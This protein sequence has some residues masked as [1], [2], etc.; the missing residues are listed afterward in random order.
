MAINVKDRKIYALNN[1]RGLDKENKPL[2]VASFRATE[3]KNFVIDSKTLKTRQAVKFNSNFAP[4]ILDTGDSIVDFYKFHDI[5]IY[6]TKKHF[7]FYDTS[8]DVLNSGFVY[9][10]PFNETMTIQ[11][12]VGQTAFIKGTM[13]IINNEGKTPLF[14]E[15]KDSLFIF[16]VGFIFVFSKIE[17][18]L[19]PYY[20]FYELESKPSSSLIENLPSIHIPTLLIGE[21]SFD[22]VNLLSKKHKYKL[23]TDSIEAKNGNKV[24]K[25][26]T[27]YD[28]GKHGTFS[29]EIK[30]YKGMFDDIDLFPV[31]I[32]VLGEHVS[33]ED[34][35]A[36]QTSFGI[37]YEESEQVVTFDVNETYNS[38]IPAEYKVNASSVTTPTLIV[39]ESTGLTNKDFFGLT[40]DYLGSTMT[41]FNFLIYR[42]RNNHSSIISNFVYKFSLDVVVDAFYRDETSNSLLLNKKR[43]IT[44]NVYVQIHPYTNNT[45]ARTGETI[46]HNYRKTL[47]SE[48]WIENPPYPSDDL[49]GYVQI[50]N[51]DFEY[52]IPIGNFQSFINDLKVKAN[53]Y[54]F[55]NLSTLANGDKLYISPQVYIPE[56]V[57]HSSTK[58]MNSYTEWLKL[59]STPY[60]IASTP[61]T[62]N[63]NDFPDVSVW[64]PTETYVPIIKFN[65]TFV[66][67]SNPTHRQVIQSAIDSMNLSGG[68]QQIALRYYLEYLVEGQYVSERYAILVNV[69]VTI[70]SQTNY[71]HRYSVIMKFTLDKTVVSDDTQKFEFNTIDNIFELTVKDY[72][73]D[74]MNEPAIEVQ[75]NFEK[76]PDY[77]IISKSKFGTIF[78]SE[79][80]LFLSGHPSYPNIDRYNV[81][82]DLLGN[83]IASQSYEFTYF[84]SKNYRVVGGKG[85]INGYVVATDSQLYVT[86]ESYPG[87][88]KLF[89]RT[90][91]LDDNGLVVYFE[92]KTSINKTPINHKNIIRYF[93]DILMLTKDGLFAMEISSNVLTNERMLKL[94]SGFINK[95]LI[96]NISDETFLTED[97]NYLYIFSGNKVYVIDARYTA[98]NEN[99][100]IENISYEIVSWELENKHIQA[101]MIGDDF[102]L[103]ESNGEYFYNLLPDSYDDTI[104][105][106]SNGLVSYYVD[107]TPPRYYLELVDDSLLTKFNTFGNKIIITSKVYVMKYRFGEHYTSD[108]FT[109]VQIESLQTHD[110]I[111]VR[112]FDS[113][114]GKYV[115]KKSQ[116]KNIVVNPND[117]TKY[118][119]DLDYEEDDNNYSITND[120]FILMQNKPLYVTNIFEKTIGTLKTVI[121]MSMNPN[122]ILDIEDY[123]NNEDVIVG[124]EESS[125]QYLDFILVEPLDLEIYWQSSITDFENNLFEKTS[126]KT[127]IYATKQSKSNTL[128]FGYRTMRRLKSLDEG[129]S[130]ELSKILDLSNSFDFGEANFNTFALSTFNEVGM[131][132]PMKENNFLY[133]QFMIRGKGQIEVNSIEITYKLNRLLKTVG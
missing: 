124:I 27:F 80:R 17:N 105:R 66:D 48:L 74:Y 125:P 122:V 106:Y 28:N 89:I 109:I 3:G 1:F 110:Y 40:I 133:I 123:S 104:T 126:F 128:V 114:L 96:S 61:Y 93:N 21:N 84:P 78:G 49:T 5:I 81:S 100:M 69:Q 56:T 52:P 29:S 6:V 20:V 67:F 131:S 102:L 50:L 12:S 58:Q 76:N 107:G 77:T 62:P 37:L 46:H 26:P 31:F 118:L 108:G 47:D 70:T 60:R 10:N 132:F 115:Y 14:I 65:S 2:K 63:V 9:R 73:F 88:S 25:L 98:T 82:N 101:K 51:N 24:F 103:L 120:I 90:R 116:M 72:Y 19:N 64:N 85:A 86:K 23:F 129:Q 30:M 7:W 79:N 33:E 94:R 8:R 36:L 53:G 13:P 16:C 32:G 112:R 41:I 113:V 34:E 39:S 95:D 11:N 87:D 4:F 22:D 55:E 127:N 43:T 121:R 35:V 54:L 117:S 119:F 111:Y 15:E 92:S 59:S 91:Q 75:V 83:N 97:E 44:K 45:F 99:S 68:S 38:S 18:G 130:L 71:E 42:I 57:I